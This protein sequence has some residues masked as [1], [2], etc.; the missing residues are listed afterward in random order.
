[1]TSRELDGDD[2]LRWRMSTLEERYEKQDERL[3]AVEYRLKDV[4]I[5]LAKLGVKIGIWAAL[6]AG[7]PIVAAYVLQVL[8]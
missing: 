8:K 7:I 5:G 3:A 2:T 4:E 6:G 1:M